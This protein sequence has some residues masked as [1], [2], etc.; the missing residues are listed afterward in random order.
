MIDIRQMLWGDHIRRSTTI[1]AALFVFAAIVYL[2]VVYSA[3]IET[4]VIRDRF[5]KNAEPLFNGEFPVMEYPPLAIVFI[6]LPR[7]FGPTPWSYEV[8]YV[9]EVCIFVIIG[10]VLVSRIAKLLGQN[11]VRAMMAYSILT[12]L[13]IEFVL[14][15]F[16]IFAMVIVLASVLMFLEKRYNWAFVLL[17]VGILVKVYPA[18][19]FLVYLIFLMHGGKVREGLVGTLVMVLIGLSTVAVCWVIDPQII[20]NFLSY[21][22]G[23]PL[24]IEAAASSVIYFLGQFGL[25]DVWIQPA[26]AESFWSDN[27]RGPLAD[28]VADLLLPLMVVC[29]IAVSAFYLFVRMRGARDDCMQTASL[30]IVACILVFFLTNKVFSSQYLIWLIGP[31]VVAIMLQERG[32][33]RKLFHLTVVAMVLVQANFAYSCGYLGGGADINAIGMAMVLV[34]NLVLGYMLVLVL[35]RMVT[36]TRPD[37]PTCCDSAGSA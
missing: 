10:L 29:V 4:E 31:L 19:L 17:A 8:A 14:D 18:V 37:A 26:S 34:K 22:T 6:A 28:Q 36:M 35:R 13:M 27:L 16:D 11:R 9:A 3:G 2:V 33:G 12:V 7:F 23:R 15:R 30:A 25:T 5:W 21:N 32:F 1:M 24:Q 20:T